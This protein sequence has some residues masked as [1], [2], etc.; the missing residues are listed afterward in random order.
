MKLKSH[1]IIVKLMILANILFLR[2]VSLDWVS[3]ET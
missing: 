2:N 1:P 3:R